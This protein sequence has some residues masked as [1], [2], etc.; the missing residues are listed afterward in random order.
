MRHGS[1]CSGIGGFDLAA[2]WAGWENVFACEI[3]TFCQKVL[4][5]RFPNTTIVGNIYEFDT[6]PYVGK[7]DVISAGFPCQPFSVAGKK[8]GTQDDRYLWDEVLR[9]VKEIRPLWLV[10]ENVLGLLNIEQGVAFENIC[11]SLESAGYEVQPLI[12]PACAVGAPHK[13]DRVWIVA[14]DTNGSATRRRGTGNGWQ[15]NGQ[16]GSTIQVQQTADTESSCIERQYARQRKKQSGGSSWRT[17]WFEAA[18]KLCRVDDGV[19][20]RMDRLKALGNAIVPQVAYQIFKSI[21]QT[22]YFEQKA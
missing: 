4:N 15:V 10:A 9:V 8:K 22:V 12:V 16:S 19:P 5:K 13:R 11:A 7:I 21:E 6:R 18:T 20:D 17:Y 1:L 2:E 14:K 3:D